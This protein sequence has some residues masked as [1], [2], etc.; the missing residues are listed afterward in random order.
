MARHKTGVA[1][2][3]PAKKNG[4]T[5]K[6]WFARIEFVDESGIRKRVERRPDFNTKT[7]AHEK[8]RQMLA[9]LDDNSSVFD[10]TAMTFSQ[11]AAYYQQTYLIEPQYRDGRKIAGLRSKYDFEKRL[12]PL[13]DF[14]GSK[15]LR[16]IT[17]GDL[18]K[19]KARRLRTPVVVGRN[20]RG[21]EPDGEPKER[22]R[23]IATVHRELSFMRR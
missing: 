14:F 5:H 2:A 10:A 17:H 13:K 18:Q 7:S 1:I 6:S 4:K 16:S 21:T 12:I 15:K 3:R 22:E 20:T 11:L 19:Y 23:S 9:E 8:A